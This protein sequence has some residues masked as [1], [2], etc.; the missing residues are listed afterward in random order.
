[1]NRFHCL[2]PITWSQRNLDQHDLLFFPSG[3][4]GL[5]E[6]KVLEQ[7]HSQ[8]ETLRCAPQSVA[9]DSFS[10]TWELADTQSPVLLHR[11]LFEQAPPPIGVGH[12]LRNVGLDNQ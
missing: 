4:N 10:I 9:L 8:P 2:F 3:R 6:W 11:N 1:M 12:G 5:R 7:G